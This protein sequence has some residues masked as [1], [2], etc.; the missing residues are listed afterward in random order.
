MP[1]NQNN[2]LGD[3]LRQEREKRGITIEQV[4][5]ATKIS[6]RILHFLEADQ[7]SELPAKPFIRGFIT[8]Y[9]RFIGLNSKEVLTHHTDFIESKSQSRPNL[10]KSHSGYAF[11]KREGEQ[12]RTF[13]W[14]L[15]G[16][17][18]LL[19]GLLIFVL[20]PSF[21]HHRPTRIE[22][23]RTAHSP[24]PVASQNLSQAI[25]ASPT[26]APS[27]SPSP[28][29]SPSP[30]PSPSVQPSPS[31]QPSPSPQLSPSTP[32]SPTPKPD[33]LNSGANLSPSEIRFKVL[34]KALDDIWVRY[35]VDEKPVMKFPIRKEGILVLR[36]K[37]TIRF[38]VSDP[39]SVSFN[40]NNRGYKAMDT[41]KNIA[42][43]QKNATLFFP[44]ELSKI[45]EEPF[46]GEK[47]LSTQVPPPYRAASPIPTASP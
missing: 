16:S 33:K 2:S 29:L 38:Q 35:Q 10:S 23:L 25:N 46:P 14:I 24:Q 27:P 11:E 26:S 9:C 21:R 36:A 15:M 47:P 18:V 31:S 19:G 12:N 44:F 1:A 7:Y 30:E 45:I 8:A 5:S 39:K 40:L 32:L 34:F 4:A 42:M 43:R 20:K 28:T 3:F 13:L 22:K 41:E 17:F 6:V 37:K